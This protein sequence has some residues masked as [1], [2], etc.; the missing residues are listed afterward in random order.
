MLAQLPAIY[1]DKVSCRYMP[2]IRKFFWIL[3]LINYF[4]CFCA[5][6]NNHFSAYQSSF[7]LDKILSV[8]Y[9]EFPQVDLY[10]LF[11]E[12]ILLLDGGTDS[13]NT[14]K[15]SQSSNLIVHL[16]CY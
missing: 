8:I 14:F 13:T 10:C 5:F 1:V 12:A 11:Q 15:T 9:L 2:R 7:Q 4:Y 16:I 3:I 6:R